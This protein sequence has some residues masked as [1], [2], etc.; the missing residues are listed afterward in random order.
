MTVKAEVS[1]NKLLISDAPT[2]LRLI[3]DEL[4]TD[5]KQLTDDR[6]ISH[7]HCLESVFT[8]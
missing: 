8:H 3:I 7:Y 4:I 5:A 1:L 6:S 2:L